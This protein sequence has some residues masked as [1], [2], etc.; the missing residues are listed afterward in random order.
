MPINLCNFLIT[1]IF[2][3]SRKREDTSIATQ[4][5]QISLVHEGGGG[6][7]L[8]DRSWQ[9]LEQNLGNIPPAM[10]VKGQTGIATHYTPI[11]KDS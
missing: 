1:N 3:L 6:Q 11:E 2:I 4:E 10:A 8:R 7:F 9:G 5:R